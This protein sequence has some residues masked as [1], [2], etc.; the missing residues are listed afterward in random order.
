MSRLELTAASYLPADTLYLWW[1]GQPAQPALVGTLRWVRS[2][3][4]VSLQYAPSWLQRGFALSEDLPLQSQE[5]MPLA[6]DTAV[7]A[8]DDA[9]PDRWGERVIRFLDRPSRLSLME[10]LLFAGDERFGALGVSVS[11]QV[12]SPRWTGP[13]PQLTE[14]GDVHQAIARIQAGEAMPPAMQRLVS[15]GVTMGGARPKALIDIDG[16]PGAGPT[17]ATQRRGRAVAPQ[18]RHARRRTGQRIHADQ[19]VERGGAIRAH[20]R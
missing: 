16:L 3:R 10:Y 4:S 18:T 15:P 20:A 9:R 5:L 14:L 2:Q 8:V 13:L 7:G 1:L 11:D 12:Y 17:A 19:R 6:A